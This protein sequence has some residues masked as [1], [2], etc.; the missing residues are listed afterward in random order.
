MLLILLSEI[1]Y[2]Y[3]FSV[4]FLKFL[5]FEQ[6]SVDSEMPILGQPPRLIGEYYLYFLGVANNVR[7]A[8]FV[9]H[10]Q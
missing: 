10:K 1:T 9:G 7:L 2:I 6:V 4:F 3:F 8:R 5:D